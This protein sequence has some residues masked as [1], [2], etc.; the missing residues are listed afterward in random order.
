M[1]QN[2]GIFGSLFGPTPGQAVNTAL[3]AGTIA[4]N[5]SGLSAAQQQSI[6]DQ[7]A[8]QLDLYKAQI[9]KHMRDQGAMRKPPQIASDA[10]RHNML[11]MRLHMPEGAKLPFPYMSTA[12]TDDKVFVF[13]I[14]D[15][16]AVTLS[17]ER[18][19]FPSDGLVAQIRLLLP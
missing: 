18:A 4:S 10:G 1:E 16:Q 14:V 15:R 2:K 7:Y 13:L 12:L 11:A 5:G 17:D 3:G 6:Q 19:I 8:R 9:E